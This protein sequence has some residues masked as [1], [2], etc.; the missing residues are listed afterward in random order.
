LIHLV[1]IG[2]IIDIEIGHIE[3]LGVVLSKQVRE[4]G[5]FNLV[6]PEVLVFLKQLRMKWGRPL[7]LV[8]I[9]E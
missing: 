6:W 2:V 7:A 5:V 8:V 1:L 3:T 9:S 4:F